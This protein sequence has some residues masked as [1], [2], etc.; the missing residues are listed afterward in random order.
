MAESGGRQKEFLISNLNSRKPLKLQ[1]RARK[2]YSFK[3]T[4]WT[5]CSLTYNLKMRRE[6]GAEKIFE[7]IMAE[8][9]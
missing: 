9:F 2:M 7:E 5:P 8:G 1:H 4:C 3:V 6:K